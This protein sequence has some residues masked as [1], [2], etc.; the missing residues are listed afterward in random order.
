MSETVQ[1]AT[2]SEKEHKAK[3]EEALSRDALML[4]AAGLGEDEFNKYR[5]VFLLTQSDNEEDKKKAAELFKAYVENHYVLTSFH[6]LYTHFNN[7]KLGAPKWLDLEYFLKPTAENVAILEEALKSVVVYSVVQ[8]VNHD[9]YYEVAFRNSETDGVVETKIR[10]ADFHVFFLAVMGMI[11]LHRHPTLNNSV[12]SIHRLSQAAARFK[13]FEEYQEF[14]KKAQMETEEQVDVPD[15]NEI[16][17]Q[18]ICVNEGHAHGGV[19]GQFTIEVYPTESDE[20]EHGVTTID[21]ENEYTI[22]LV[23]PNSS[24]LFPYPDSQAQLWKQNPIGADAN[25]KWISYV[26]EMIAKLKG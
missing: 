25:D 9:K 12:N 10:H 15:Y 5:E 1:H 11:N 23:Y 7:L 2:V 19:T 16:E 13:S 3:L 22:K 18:E 26:E 14:L 4:S 17:W 6:I 20:D 21:P 8:P 24:I